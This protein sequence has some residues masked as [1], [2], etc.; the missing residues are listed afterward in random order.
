MLY[1]KYIYFINLIFFA[2][3]FNILITFNNYFQNNFK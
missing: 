3:V 1:I 2:L